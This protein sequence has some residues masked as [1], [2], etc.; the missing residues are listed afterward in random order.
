MEAV[1][2]A[3][4]GQT[5]SK[6]AEAVDLI[7]NFGA[8]KAKIESDIVASRKTL[9]GLATDIVRAHEQ[10]AI[11]KRQAEQLIQAG[12]EQAANFIIKAESDGQDLIAEANE[13]K[14]KIHAEAIEAAEFLENVKSDITASKKQLELAMK[15]E[16]ESQA[17]IARLRDDAK[18][19]AGL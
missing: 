10:I 4:L 7:E 13:A 9:D 6:V 3:K 8:V 11:H 1:K 16:S 18:R 12:K 15:A 14:A 19:M 2:L 17:R 5:L